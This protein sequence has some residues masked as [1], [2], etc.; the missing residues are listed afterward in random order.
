MYSSP[1]N[2]NYP[3]AVFLSFFLQD[4]NKDVVYNNNNNDNNNNTS[5]K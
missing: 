4:F 2:Y 3:T 5:S 1:R